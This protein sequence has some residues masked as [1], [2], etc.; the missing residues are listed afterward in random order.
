MKAPMTKGRVARGRAVAGDENAAL[1]RR[2]RVAM[3]EAGAYSVLSPRFS[4][5]GSIF[6]S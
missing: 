5:K 1:G 4:S 3:Q 6:A 2:F